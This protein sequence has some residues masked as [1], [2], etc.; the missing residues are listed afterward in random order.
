MV[1]ATNVLY[2]NP[3]HGSDRADGSQNRPYRTITYGLT[4]AIPGTTLRLAEGTYTV[5]SGETFPLA[6]P[7]SVLLLGNE[8]R[9][10]RGIVIQGGGQY[11]SPTFAWQ[12]V[13]IRL[14]NATQ[15]RGVTVINPMPKG[16][17]VW[18]ESTTPTI[19]RCTF[20]HCGREGIFATGT[21]NP[22]IVENVFQNNSAS[23]ISI[24]RNGKGEIRRNQ[25][26]QT[27]YGIAIS[28]NAAPLVVDNELVDNRCGMVLSGNARPVLRR[29]RMENNREQ[30][31]LILGT[32][33]PDFG[34]R[35]D[36]GGNRFQ[37][38]GEAD[39]Q[40]DT[41]IALTSAGNGINLTRTRGS[42]KLIATEI[43]PVLP[44]ASPVPVPTPA[45]LPIVVPTPAPVPAPGQVVLTD[46]AG[47]WAESFVQSLVDRGI[48]SGFGD[49]TFR[50]DLPVPRVQ[51]AAAIAKTFNL[52]SKRDST[53]FVDVPANFWAAAAIAKAERM[54]FISGFPDQTFRPQQNLTCIQTL[55]SLVNGLTLTGGNPNSLDIYRDRAEVPSYAV[56]AVATATQRRMVV[57]H[58]Q[59]NELEPM[60]DITRAEMAALLYQA[61]VA[62][63]Q[64]PAITSPYI[65]VPNMAAPSFADVQ[66][67]WALGFIKGLAS[68]GF[69]SGFADGTFR[70][71]GEMTRA[72][73]AI[74]LATVFNPTPKRAAIAFPDVPPNFWAA[75][76]IQRVSQGGLL[77]GSNDGNFLPNQPVTRLQVFLSLANGL[78]LPAGNDDRLSF[79][80][81]GNTIPVYARKAMASA[82]ASRLVVNYPD[83][84]VLHP[85]RPAT[86]A[87]VAAI[88]YQ[89][90]VTL[91]RSPILLSPYIVEPNEGKTEPTNPVPVPVPVPTPPS[92]APRP[93]SRLIV[94]DPGHGGSDPGAIGIGGLR[95]KDVVLPITVAI[96]T[97][98]QQQ[99]FR[100]LLTRSDDRTLE[101]NER[102]RIANQAKADLLV[103]IHGNSAGL[104][105]PE[106][107]GLETYH[108]PGS[109]PSQTLA[110]TIHNHILKTVRVRDRRVREGNLF[111]LRHTT[112]PA[113]LVEVGFLTGQ[114]DGPRLATPAYQRELARAIATGI[115]QYVNT[116]P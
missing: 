34:D 75:P 36:P 15:L 48:I 106:I 110:A 43:P 7:D 20:V 115:A 13:T 30:G 6:I 39:V 54:G 25:F 104:D 59:V 114:E 22:E 105:R 102:T 109:R 5:N 24:V 99:G 97:L 91:G 86:R 89:A 71:D 79:Y 2:I 27:G 94:L 41:G 60:V 38:N 112:M 17:A 108:Y 80:R 73:Y 65:V 1:Q 116:I 29:N 98:L 77:S 46:I 69:I 49:R 33:Q 42:L 90:T 82:M 10:G 92:A 26:N 78:A 64:A 58:P 74:L 93:H 76:A 12:V 37:N 103:S 88:V 19:A 45:P 83:R 111:V 51:Y 47:H 57:N 21:A 56:N 113:V 84:R 53:G 100:V 63:G 44:A 70:P 9:T 35:H 8:I 52:P 14:G 16:T 68:Q 85:N 101:L 61:L 4:Q 32:A 31:L 62:L 95:E 55:V 40:N 23:G 67:H 50:P 66:N 3:M 28:D 81:D 96:A 18:I 107:H 72:Q 87:E 11:N